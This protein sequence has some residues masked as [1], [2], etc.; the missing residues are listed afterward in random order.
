MSA[1]IQLLGVSGRIVLEAEDTTVEG[2]RAAAEAAGHD[3][4]DLS[5]RQGGE[6][7]GDGDSVNPEAP[8][9]TSPPEV[10]QGR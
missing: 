5:L 2:V 4:S 9:V 8:V 1:T 7:L 10:K 3:I 6:T